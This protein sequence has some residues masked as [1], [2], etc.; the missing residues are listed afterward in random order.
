MCKR[1]EVSATIPSVLHLVQTSNLCKAYHEHHH[2]AN[3]SGRPIIFSFKF[4]CC[5]SNKNESTTA[6]EIKKSDDKTL[7]NKL[8]ARLWVK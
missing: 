7:R 1:L 4:W 8:T 6:H 3:D 2:A 5:E